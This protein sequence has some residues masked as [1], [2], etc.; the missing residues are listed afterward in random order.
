LNTTVGRVIAK[1]TRGDKL[2]AEENGVDCLSTEVLWLDVIRVW[3][4]YTIRIGAQKKEIF[5][6]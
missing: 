1:W 4:V 2:R 3:K 6:L 5:F